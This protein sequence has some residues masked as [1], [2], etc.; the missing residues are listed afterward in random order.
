MQA[1]YPKSVYELDITGDSG[2]YRGAACAP[3]AVPLPSRAGL[4]QFF[5]AAAALVKQHGFLIAGGPG[6]GNRL[7]EIPAHL[8]RCMGV[9]REHQ[10]NACR[11]S[12]LQKPWVRIALG[13]GFVP[14]GCVQFN[15]AARGRHRI[16]HR[17]VIPVQ[18]S[19]RY[20]PEFFHQVRVA[21]NIEQS[22]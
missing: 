1:V 21:Q 17:F 12:Q 13:A 2:F 16:D 4:R 15:H 3:Q 11:A 9:G 5:R 8:V 7:G 10:G 18:I 22:T 20:K 6:H 19:R 14:T